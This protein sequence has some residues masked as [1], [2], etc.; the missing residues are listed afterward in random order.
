MGNHKSVLE[1]CH[2]IEL[3]KVPL[4]KKNCRVLTVLQQKHRTKSEGFQE[5]LL[6]FGRSLVELLEEKG[7]GTLFR[8]WNWKAE[9]GNHVTVCGAVLSRE[10]FVFL[11]CL[12]SGRLFL[13][14]TFYS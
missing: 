13:R 14:F 6:E 5:G 9:E 2:D 8:T 1:D 12:N 7:V 3:K 10:A 11:L 4:L